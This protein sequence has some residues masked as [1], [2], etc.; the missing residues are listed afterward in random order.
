M[1]SDQIVLIVQRPER[2]WGVLLC[3]LCLGFISVLQAHSLSRLKREFSPQRML[4]SADP[5]AVQSELEESTE[6]FLKGPKKH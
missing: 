5:Q 6:G 3:V 1:R 2:V 4:S